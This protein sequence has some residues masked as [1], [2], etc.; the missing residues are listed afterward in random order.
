M[1]RATNGIKIIVKEFYIS[2][3]TLCEEGDPKLTYPVNKPKPISIHTLCE[4]GDDI[5]HLCSYNSEI[6]IHTLCEEG[7]FRV[8]YKPV[9]IIGDF[10]PHPL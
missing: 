1:K 9:I 6:S 7:D 5:P 3:H 4:E 2:I 10:N 8:F